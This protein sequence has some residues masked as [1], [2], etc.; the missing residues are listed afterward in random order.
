MRLLRRLLTRGEEMEEHLALETAENLQA[1]MPPAEA[2]RQ[3]V[4]K[5]GARRRYGGVSRGA[6]AA[7]PRKSAARFALRPSHT[8]KVA[9][10]SLPPRF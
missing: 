3:A 5:F 4:L 10:G 9:G 7:V 2:R 8:D 6:R 1:G